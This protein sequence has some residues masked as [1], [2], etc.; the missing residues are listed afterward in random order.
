MRGTGQIE[1][2]SRLLDALKKLRAIRDHAPHHA[3][4]DEARIALWEWQ[5]NR[6]RRQRRRQVEVNP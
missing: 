5:H 4:R 2:R 3:A 6:D 1:L